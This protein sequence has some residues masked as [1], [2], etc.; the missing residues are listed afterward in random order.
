MQSTRKVTT[1]EVRPEAGAAKAG[2]AEAGATEAGAA[3]AAAAAASVLGAVT[4]TASV[5]V[6]AAQ[7]EGPTLLP[8][9]LVPRSRSHSDTVPM[10]GTVRALAR[11]SV[12]A[13]GRWMTSFRSRAGRQ[14]L[15]KPQLELRH[16]AG[17]GIAEDVVGSKDVTSRYS[18]ILVG[19]RL[20]CA[21]ARLE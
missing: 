9:L 13:S 3:A 2:A 15:P 4:A 10:G 16:G 19:T 20:I 1:Y 6:V 8:N 7:E 18:R 5:A 12:H 14:G 17:P 21:S 11:T